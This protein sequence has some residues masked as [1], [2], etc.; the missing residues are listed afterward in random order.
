MSVRKFMDEYRAGTQP[1]GDGRLLRAGRV[2]ITLAPHR[3][4]VTLCRIE[5]LD[6]GNG[7][8]SRALDWLCQLADKYG[9]KISGCADP[10]GS[11]FL[12]LEK[13]LDW[14]ARHGFKITV[15]DFYYI[16]REPKGE[17]KRG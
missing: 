16:D 5:A 8:G 17:V 13:L 11:C 9:V 15:K 7:D 6:A 3:T 12:D 4:W 14:Y 1:T 2:K 10:F